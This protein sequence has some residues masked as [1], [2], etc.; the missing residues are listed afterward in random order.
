M[1]KAYIE[2]IIPCAYTILGIESFIIFSMCFRHPKALVSAMPALIAFWNIGM[3]TG[4]RADN[5]K[6]YLAN[7]NKLYIALFC[8]VC[9]GVHLGTLAYLAVKENK[10][11]CAE[12]SRRAE[13][14]AIERKKYNEQIKACREFE[15]FNRVYDYTIPRMEL[16]YNCG[17]N[18]RFKISDEALQKK[19][20]EQIDSIIKRQEDARE[21]LSDCCTFVTEVVMPN[22]DNINLRQNVQR[23]VRDVVSWITASNI[24]CRVYYKT[25]VRGEVQN[26]YVE[27]HLVKSRTVAESKTFAQE[28]RALVTPKIRFEVLKRDNFT[29][30]YCGAHGEGVV[31]EV[32][33][34]IPISKG[35]TSDMGNLITACFDCNRGKGSDLVTDKQAM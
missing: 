16:I 18:Q 23:K 5:G 13:Q 22:I 25:P 30:Q 34:I 33:H 11:Q 15:E 6:L 17:S 32:D 1:L 28:Q 8:L 29:C 4:Y 24:R 3:C 21:S 7:A 19:F 35:G 20:A 2:Q 31:L 10:R 12:A 14:E 26:R 9:I 27:L